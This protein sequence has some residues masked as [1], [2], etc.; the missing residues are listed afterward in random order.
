MH[1]TKIPPLSHSKTISNQFHHPN[2]VS[3]QDAAEETRGLSF[4]FAK[5]PGSP[6]KPADVLHLQKTVGNQAVQRLLADRHTSKPSLV[7]REIMSVSA[8]QKLTYI[9][10]ASRKKIKLVDKA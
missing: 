7:Q 8:F 1:K 9:R 4:D 6:L 2:L 3:H 5:T 10:A